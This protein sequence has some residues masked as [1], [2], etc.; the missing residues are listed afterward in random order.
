MQAR[1]EQGT[2]ADRA[3]GSLWLQYV[4]RGA[5]A[6]RQRSASKGRLSW[7]EHLS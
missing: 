3:K 6:H 2:G 7:S 1:A 4:T 5:A